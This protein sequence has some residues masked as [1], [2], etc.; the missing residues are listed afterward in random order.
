M[1]NP[2]SA[3][4]EPMAVI[5][6]AHL[7]RKTVEEL[8]QGLIDVVCYPFDYGVMVYVHCCPFN[9]EPRDL[10]Q[11]HDAAIEHGI[12]WVRFDADAPICEGL[13]TYDWEDET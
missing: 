9:N 6:T 1:S 11:A 8:T 13:P 12:V 4:V 7:T 3:A 5:S 2:F 10:A